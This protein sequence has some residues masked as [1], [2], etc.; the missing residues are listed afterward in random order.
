MH[1]LLPLPLLLLFAL[2]AHAGPAWSLYPNDRYGYEIGVPPGFIGQ[3]EPDAGDGQ[4]FR[5]ADGN[6]VLTVWGGYLLD[7]FADEAG[8]RLAALRKGGW[9]LTYQATTPGWASY[10]GTKG[11][12]VTYFRE[13]A[14]CRDTQYAAFELQYPSTE[15]RA[16]NE[17]VSKLVASLKQASC[18][19]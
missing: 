16:M 15:I 10:S 18:P 17:V 7:G 4:V 6:S 19:D 11:R 8:S 2:P 5:S 13:I 3:D 1:R 12:R 9:T 14:G